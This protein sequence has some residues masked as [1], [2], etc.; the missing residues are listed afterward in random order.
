MLDDVTMLVLAS[1]RGD[2]MGGPK[3]LLAWTDGQP[4]A[5]V[6]ASLA[7]SVGSRAVVVVRASVASVLRPMMREPVVVASSAPSS[8][9]PAGSI[10]AAV[11]AGALTNTSWVMLMPVDC[12]PA[13]LSTLTLLCQLAC[14]GVDAVRPVHEGRGGHPVLVRA[15]VLVH[16]YLTDRLRPLRDV[17]SG[18]GCMDV[19]VGDV[20]VAANLNTPEAY[21]AWVGHEPRFVG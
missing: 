16:A 8:C 21:R 15:D 19:H 11:R 14:E 7:A 13:S 6:H 2:R 10:A 17:I 12:V 5:K 20:R 1:G 9:G 3:A 18:L 4:L